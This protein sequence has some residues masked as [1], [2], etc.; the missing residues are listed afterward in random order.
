MLEQIRQ[1]I[2]DHFSDMVEIRRY[3]HQ[4]PELSFQEYETAKY[5]ANF[6][7]NLGI[8]YQTNVGGNGVI[9]TLKGGQ[10]GKTIALRADFDA[11]PIQ[12]ENAVAYKSKVDGIMHACGHDG[13]T[14]TLLVLAKVMQTYQD[15]LPGTVVFVHQ[16]AEEYAPGGAKSIVESGA[17]DHVDAVFGT[18][19]WATTPLG[20]VQTA[21]DVLMA[22][23]DRFEITI[24]GHGGHGAYPHETKDA[25]VIGAQIVTALQQI[26][27]RRIDPLE[28]AVVT[29]GQFQAGDAFNIIADQARL[30]GT[31]RYLK[32]AIQEQVI[33]EMEKM[34][35]G[36]CKANGA[37]YDLNYVKG[38]PPLA[39]HVEEATLI[40]EAS[41]NIKDIH[42]REEIRPVMGGEDFAYYIKQKPGA[43]FFTGAQKEDNPYPHHHPKFDIDERAMPIAAK[44]LLGVYFAYQNK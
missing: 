5:I 38:Y 14:A 33:T 7:E 27:S 34:V 20:V 21:K 43:Y 26:T 25:I 17:L 3:L 11:L 22:G 31:V 4:Y 6:Y 2:D 9:A 19:L 8:P 16:H 15:D 1:S 41:Q 24:Q 37:T 29:V 44:T 12:E 39:N 35:D 10:P 18:H 30:T 36:I 32:T 42:S 23:A 13:H 40:L 28:T